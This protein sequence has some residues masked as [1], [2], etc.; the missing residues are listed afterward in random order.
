MKAQFLLVYV[1]V[2]VTRIGSGGFIGRGG[3]WYLR[4]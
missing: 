2:P 4:S 3:G 1:L